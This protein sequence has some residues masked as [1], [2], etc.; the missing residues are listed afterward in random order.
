M[1]RGRPRATDQG[2]NPAVGVAGEGPPVGC[3]LRAPGQARAGAFRPARQDDPEHAPGGAARG[4]GDKPAGAGVAGGA[5]PPPPRLLGQAP[6]GAGAENA[7]TRRVR[8]TTVLL[9]SSMCSSTSPQDV[10]GLESFGP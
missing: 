8:G 3:R 10:W 7:L 4:R 5:V 2:R 9:A 1:G 6:A